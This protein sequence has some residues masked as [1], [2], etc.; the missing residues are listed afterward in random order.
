MR[1]NK[2]PLR[3]FPNLLVVPNC[4]K[5]Q[6]EFPILREYKRN[7][8]FGRRKNK[9]KLLMKTYLTYRRPI[10]P[11][12]STP[13]AWLAEMLSNCI[14]SSLT[15]STASVS[16]HPRAVNPTHTIDLRFGC[17]FMT[18]FGT[19]EHQ[20]VLPELVTLMHW[21]LVPYWAKG[22]PP[23][24]STINA[25]IEKLTEAASWRGRWMRGQ[26]CI[27]PATGTCPKLSAVHYERV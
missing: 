27:M 15:S 12:P 25:T 9:A 10:S 14:S 22:I 4:L 17:T 3:H 7:W 2:W 26:R 21:G 20:R 5:H 16:P 13:A 18:E 6:P 8:S 24:F 11:T 23:K 19:L 1:I